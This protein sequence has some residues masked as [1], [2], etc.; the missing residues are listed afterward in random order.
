MRVYPSEN[1]KYLVSRSTGEIEIFMKIDVWTLYLKSQFY[2]LGIFRYQIRVQQASK[3]P[4]T[5]FWVFLF[6][7]KVFDFFFQTDPNTRGVWDLQRSPPPLHEPEVIDPIFW[8]SDS[9]GLFT[10][11]ISCGKNIVQRGLQGVIKVWS[12]KFFW[13]L[14]SEKL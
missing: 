13:A 10:W 9:C 3:T 14:S 12:P 4:G 11:N 6:F 2:M 1:P 8:F 7:R 5:N